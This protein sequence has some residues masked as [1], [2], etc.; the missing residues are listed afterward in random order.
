[1]H[2]DLDG[3]SPDRVEG[4]EDVEGGC[5]TETEDGL[6][7]VQDYECLQEN[8]TEKYINTQ[9]LL[10]MHCAAK[11]GT[12]AVNRGAKASIFIP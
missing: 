2:E 5:G 9:I 3:E 6:P 8:Q 7:F 1:M 10:I 12:K 4:A 11:K